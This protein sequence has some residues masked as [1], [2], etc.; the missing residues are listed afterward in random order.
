[1]NI[2]LLKA[3]EGF[4]ASETHD[5]RGLERDSP[6]TYIHPDFL[7]EFLTPCLQL[8]WPDLSLQFCQKVADQISS[9]PGYEIALLWVRFLELLIGV[10]EGANVPLSTPQYRSFATVILEAYLGRYVRTEPS[11]V[12]DYSGHGDPPTLKLT[13]LRDNGT[14]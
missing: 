6:G 13:N 3:E 5:R 2:S 14:L 9:V 10:L 8:N 11:L 7:A 12:S 1:M 4:Y